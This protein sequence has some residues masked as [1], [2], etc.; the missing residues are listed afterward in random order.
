MEL[1]F[2]A[3][4]YWRTRVPDFQAWV[5]T[6]P[7]HTT[8]EYLRRMLQYLQ[9]Q[10]GGKQGRSLVLKSPLHVGNLDMVA[11]HFPRATVVHCHRDPRVAMPSTARLY[12][13]MRR[14]ATDVVDLRAIGDEVLKFWGDAAAANL[15]QRR[16]LA[17]QLPIIDVRYE[18]ILDDPLTAIRS[19]LAVRELE[20]TGSA[21]EAVQQWEAEN[22]Q[23][24]HG[25]H[26]YEAAVYGLND[27]RIERTFADYLEHFYPKDTP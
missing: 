8:Y 3:V 17:G 25:R 27:A 20:I 5:R 22:P 23:H 4:S 9:W 11:E 12:E 18:E 10:Q 1:T 6:R 21:I 14:M 24:A 7:R 13:L 19:I 15:A 26:R 16:E 2:E